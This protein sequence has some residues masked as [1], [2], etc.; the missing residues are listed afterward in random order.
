[1]TN[2]AYEQDWEAQGFSEGW[3]DRLGV[4]PCWRGRGVASALLLRSM[5]SFYEAGLDAAGIGIDSERPPLT[6]GHYQRLGYQVVS[7]VL[8]HARTFDDV[9]DRANR[10]TELVGKGGDPLEPPQGVALD[11]PER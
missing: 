1:V 4:R 3:T 6:S 5:Q 7:L 8:L 9:E 10:L 11:G 2:A